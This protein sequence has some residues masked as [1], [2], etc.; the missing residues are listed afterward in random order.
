M[1]SPAWKRRARRRFTVIIGVLLGL[2]L[3]DYVSYPYLAHP[4]GSN[5]NRGENGLWLR[6]T[7]Y[8]G[9][10]KDVPVLAER[11]KNEQIRYAYFH[12]RDVTKSGTLR[13]HRPDAA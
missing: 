2:F 13:H 1:K 10:E 4:A 7:W 3:L 6:Y 5:F 12:V 9:E 8:F 11:L